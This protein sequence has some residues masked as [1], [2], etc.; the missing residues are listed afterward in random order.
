MDTL[1][2]IWIVIAVVLAGVELL[3]VQLVS[4]WFVIGAVAA[5]IA[6]AFGADTAIQIIIFIVTSILVLI[7]LRPLLKKKLTVKPEPM[8]ADRVIGMNAIV[9]DKIDNSLGQGQVNV[10]G[11]IW[12]ARSK[13]NDIIEKNESVIVEKIEG[14]KLIVSFLKK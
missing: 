5:A 1:F 2:W 6:N 9:I 12:T 7:F 10:N 3:T 14:V 8:N 4:I 11:Q 13:N